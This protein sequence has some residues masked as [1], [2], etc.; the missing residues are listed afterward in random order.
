[1]NKLMLAAVLLIA[2][3]PLATAQG[4]YTKLHYPGSGYTFALGVNASGQVVGYYIMG[5]KS[6]RGGFL[7]TGGQF[8]AINFPDAGTTVLTGINDTGEISGWA[9]TNDKEFAF[10]YNLQTQTFTELPLFHYP[11]ATCINDSGMVGGITKVQWEGY[12]AGF[13]WAPGQ[14]PVV[15]DYP[16]SHAWE[17]IV[18]GI[19]AS[20]G[21]VGYD[22]VQPDGV[23]NFYY[24]DG[25]FQAITIPGLTYPTVNGTNPAGTVL[26]GQYTAGADFLSFL[27]SDGEVETLSFP[28]SDSTFANGVNATGEVVGYFYS[29]E[30]TNGFTWTPPAADEKK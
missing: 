20:G 18:T 13:K 3:L 22:Q 19:T 8:E 9:G 5:A 7:Y 21:L 1:M 17:T 26:V 16:Q 23:D 4:T 28:G 11:E 15:I 6:F 30:G 25:V 12:W 29:S 24:N 10:T 2:S 27:Y 14:Q